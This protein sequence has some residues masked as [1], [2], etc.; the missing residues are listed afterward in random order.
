V[1]PAPQTSETRTKRVGAEQEHATVA[2]IVRELMDQLSW[3]KSRELVRTGRVTVDG[4]QCFDPA[5]RLHSG[6]LVE[7]DPTAKRRRTPTLEPERLVYVDAELVVVEKPAGLISV[8]LD[9]HEQRDSLIERTRVAL[10]SHGAGRDRD[11]Q[12]KPA[13]DRL[14]VVQRLDEQTTGLL[15][16]ARNRRAR[17]LLDA[18][19]MAHTVERRYVA[20][21]HGRAEA[22]V[23][24]NYL[25]PDRGDGLRGSWHGPKLP[26]AAKRAITKVRV[27][28]RLRAPSGAELTLLS[29]RIETG[30]QH[31]IRI[32]LAEAGHPLVGE[33]VYGRARRGPERDQLG[34]LRPMLHAASLGFRHPVHDRPLRFESPL[35]VDFRA[36]LD[37]LQR[38]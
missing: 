24:D 21:V 14:G 7:I 18:Q 12:D 30:R 33:Q 29:C 23:Y 31:Q 28:A 25:V 2:A 4:V 37:R 35:P 16:F 26:P 22:A 17:K 36:L 6:A 5:M 8:P 11:E 32:H 15:V 13:S 3:N 20:L 10:Q 38:V 9:E 1:T 34:A 19:F 27:E